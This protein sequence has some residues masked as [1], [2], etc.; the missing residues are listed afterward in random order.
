MKTLHGEIN[1]SEEIQVPFAPSGSG[2][3]GGSAPTELND[4]MVSQQAVRL[5]FAVSDGEIEGLEDLGGGI[6]GI[7]LNNLPIN[8]FEANWDQRP[9]TMDQGV[10]GGF[11]DTEGPLTGFSATVIRYGIPVF[12][13]VPPDTDAVRLT[14]TVP[15]LRSVDSGGNLV[16]AGTLID[17]YTKTNATATEVLAGQGL[18]WGKTSSPYSWDVTIGRPEGVS[19]STNWQIVL[20]RHYMDDATVKT[21]TVT[22]I[23]SAIGINYTTHTYPGTALVAITLLNAYVFGGRIPKI[24]FKIRGRKIFL[25]TNYDSHNKTYSGVWDGSFKSYKEWSDNPVWHILDVLTTMLGLD[26]SEIDIGKFYTIAQYCDQHVPDGFGGTECR[27]TINA[28]FS[29]RENVPTFMTYLLTLC[30]SNFTQNE[31]GQVSLFCDMPGQPI[32]HLITNSN[33]IEGMFSYSSNDL[34]SRY[35]LVNVTYQNPRIYGNNDTITEDASLVA[36]RNLLDRYGVQTSDISLLGCSS[37]GQA[38][39]KARW[40]IWVNSIDTDIVSFKVMLE[41][42]VYKV[43]DLATILDERNSGYHFQGRIL[44]T[45]YS[46][47]VTTIVLDRTLALPSESITIHFFAADGA[48]VVSKTLYQSG[49]STDTVTFA[50]SESVFVGGVFILETASKIPRTCK[51]LSITKEDDFYLV[52]TIQHTEAGKYEYIDAGWTATI[53]TGSFVDITNLT[54]APVHDIV[55]TEFFAGSELFSG[56]ALNIVWQWDKPSGSNIDAWYRVVW[57]RDNLEATTTSSLKV[58]SFDI[59]NPVPGIYIITV[60]AMNPVSGITSVATTVQYNYRVEAGTSSLHPPT[61]AV[62]A[63]TSGHIFR[64]PDCHI[65]WDYNTANDSVPDALLDYVAEIWTSD[66]ITKKSTNQLTPNQQKGCDPIYFF[67][68]NVADFGSPTR[69]FEVKIYSRDRVGDLSLP[70]SV[71]FSNPAPDV[72]SG[73]N[74]ISGIG[75]VYA[76]FTPPGG[77]DVAG[78]RIWRSVTSGFTPDDTTLIY[79]GPDT[80]VVL[81]APLVETTFFYR[82]AAYDSFGKSG[83][84]ISSEYSSTTLSLSVDTWTFDG[85]VFKPNDPGTNQVSWTSGHGSKNADITYSI[86]SGNATWTSGI[87][88]LY[89]TE[90]NTTLSS[91][92]VLGVAVA[93]GTRILAT[94]H[95]GTDLIIGNGNAYIDGDKLLAG[96]VGANALITDT[97]VI[98]SGAQIQAAVIQ[99]A[100]IENGAINNAKIGN[101]ISSTGFNPTNFTAPG[102]QLDKSG[103]LTIHGGAITLYDSSGNTILASGTSATSSSNPITGA[104]ISTYI[105]NLAVGTLQIADNAITVPSTMYGSGPNDMGYT[106]QTVATV[107]VDYGDFPPTIVTCMFTANLTNYSSGPMGLQCVLYCDGTAVG[108]TAILLESL[109]TSSTTLITS[110]A[111]GAGSHTFTVQAYLVAGTGMLRM[112]SRGMLVIGSLK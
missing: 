39:R 88:Y 85:L 72:P 5:L 112:T 47:G 50:G 43:G 48:T 33:V 44:S 2:G 82:I 89:Y 23:T 64:T 19:L 110:A 99:T 10:I 58:K 31:F 80:Y 24:F 60:Y 25:P 79:D 73:I 55:V 103:N 26:L 34:E 65:H 75:S 12:L 91:S 106:A 92:N 101:V 81:T 97:A 67:R 53:P 46:S 56:S 22:E 102:W 15:T 90:G 4:T 70:L 84:N 42:M 41:A 87:L 74:I 51:I 13:S 20:R 71:V 1:V 28:Q 62:V 77:T 96:T 14:F 27:F 18:R 104:N 6:P 49:I 93:E 3:K 59:E 107:T 98:T 40:A 45:S 95:G 54:M 8:S 17:I 7:Y 52:T 69:S 63:G 105:A 30:N 78:Y 83:L 100:H 66:G 21:E 9:G 109:A 57:S 11:T 37:E 76:S 29:E 16:G 32:E 36:G 38:R 86:S 94:Y 108:N 61:D 35:T 68:Q 111:P